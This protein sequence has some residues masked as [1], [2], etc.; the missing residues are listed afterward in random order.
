MRKQIKILLCCLPIVVGLIIGGFFAFK[1]KGNDDIT[2]EDGFI[3]RQ[4][5]SPDDNPLTDDDGIIFSVSENLTCEINDTV[6][7]LYSI[8]GTVDYTLSVK[9]L[10][11]DIASIDK[12]TF[13]I[14]PKMVGK[15]KIIST[16]IFGDDKKI[17][18]STDLNIFSENMCCCFN[19]YKNNEV[20]TD[21]IAGETYVAEIERNCKYDK[22]ALLNVKTTDKF[23]NGIK[24]SDCTIE[25][26][27]SDNKIDKYTIVPNKSGKFNFVYKDE[28]FNF[29]KSFVCYA[30]TNAI[31][32][33]V[34][35]ATK[36]ENSYSM[37][38]F[39]KN[40]TKEA[41][42]DGYYD[43][44]EVDYTQNADS[45]EELE[46]AI[47]EID[48]D[49]QECLCVE[50]CAHKI[51]I[52][53]KK[54]CKFV[55]KIYSS[56]TGFCE[57]INFEIKKVLASTICFNG[58]NYSISKPKEIGFEFEPDEPKK[59]VLTKAPI[60]SLYDIELEYDEESLVIKNNKIFIDDYG[61]YS[62]EICYRNVCVLRIVYTKIN[63]YIYIINPDINIQPLG[64][65][66][67]VKQSDFELVLRYDRTNFG[68]YFKITY[69]ISSTNN[70][71]Y[72]EDITSEIYDIDLKEKYKFPY[73][74]ELT[75]NSLFICFDKSGTIEF[76]LKLKNDSNIY[77]KIT[78]IVE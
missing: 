24:D 66:S 9:V 16:L 54:V 11:E 58:K 68:D 45:L 64:G 32:Y 44:A 41:N 25:K 17:E 34:S 55:C 19:M 4:D 60:Y 38:L 29:E 35:Y 8:D 47:D 37:F 72:S 23:D 73:H 40:Y 61:T 70:D 65:F 56:L 52:A 59:F 18:R 77:I 42:L 39:D 49:K 76:A 57:K 2:D 62:V 71:D 36:D 46:V 75:S 7:L 20:V 1:P 31:D 21:L 3:D 13:C 6:R 33:E 67:I 30:Y 63:D 5:E 22:T 48:A 78:I 69:S 14:N 53:A 27:F 12:T 43:F 74:F 28:Y 10:N 51:R 26:L 15:T 50:I